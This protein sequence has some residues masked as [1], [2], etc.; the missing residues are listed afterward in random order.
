M[1]SV[2]QLNL[3]LH[4]TQS[5]YALPITAGDTDR[6]LWIS[7]SD[8]GRPVSLEGVTATMTINWTPPELSEG[9]PFGQSDILDIRDGSYAVASLEKIH[10]ITE[11]HFDGNAEA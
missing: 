11:V 7:F 4:T 3:D 8:G 6:E 10:S 1:T 2:Y 5:N 9:T